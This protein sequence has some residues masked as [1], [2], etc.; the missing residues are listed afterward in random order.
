MMLAKN[1]NLFTF[2]SIFVWV[3]IFFSGLFF[4]VG[5]DPVYAQEQAPSA[6]T[7][8]G[9]ESALINGEPTSNIFVEG[10]KWVLYMLI[11]FFSG[12]VN[13]AATV[14]AWATE[15]GYISGPTGL[16]NL[17][18][19]YSLW[20]FIRDFFNLAFIFL[21]L[22]S[23][24]GTIFQLHQ[25]NLKKNFFAIIAAAILINFSFPLTR[26]V[27]DFGNVPMYFFRDAIA[28]TGEG[29]SVVDVPLS[30][31]KQSA[32]S[33]IMFPAER[34]AASVFSLITGVVFSFMFMITLFALSVL[35]ILR[36]IKLVILLIFS[37][38][39]VAASI[40]P[41]L[42]KYGKEWWSALLSTVF[43]GP[44]AM[45]MLV[46]ALR[47]MIELN[48]SAFSQGS[49]LSTEA[50]ANSASA[51]RQNS[52]VAQ[53]VFFIPIILMWMAMSV[54]NKFGIEGAGMVMKQADKVLNWGKGAAKKSA[55]YGSGLGV[56]KWG[57]KTGARKIDSKLASTKYGKY[58]SPSAVKKAFKD[59][60]AAKKHEDEQPIEQAA[61]DIHDSLNKRISQAKNIGATVLPWNLPLTEKNRQRLKDLAHHEF[62][63]DHSE[64]GIAAFT[65]QAS[66]AAKHLEATSDNYESL[67]AHIDTAR[68]KKD[69]QEMAGILKLLVRNNDINEIVPD[70]GVSIA[71]QL[72][73]RNISDFK[74]ED[75]IRKNLKDGE[76]I[77]EDI[78]DQNG[79]VVGR[80]RTVNVMNQVMR[81]TSEVN[82][83]GK[84]TMISDTNSGKATI[85]LSLR[86]TGMDDATITGFM[87]HLGNQ[88]LA[89]GNGA[90][91][92]MVKRDGHGGFI[93]TSEAEQARNNAGKLALQDPQKIANGM[94]ADTIFQRGGESGYFSLN[95]ETAKAVMDATFGVS[96]GNQA[97]RMKNTKD[98]FKALWEQQDQGLAEYY[99]KAKPEQQ[100]AIAKI[101][102]QAGVWGVDPKD[103]GE[104]E[105]LN[106]KTFND[107]RV[108][109]QSND[110][111]IPKP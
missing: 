23:A 7:S 69:S 25:F 72:K 91:G 78:L 58:L 57:A 65:K 27:I 45:L 99:D 85:A 74:D 44:A 10:I 20:K 82:D 22:F 34:K 8:A 63:T 93:L 56:A 17:E 28:G 83:A 108:R 30:F 9:I 53:G 46:I 60:A 68:V 13:V 87:E 39:G 86:E 48:G 84:E 70:K 80:Q 37:P 76:Q 107:A 64:H 75:D 32:L 26:I 29:N 1:K 98:G 3:F 100:Y 2:I 38:L 71:S 35:F 40:V 51:A 105:R 24:F 59:R 111:T 47:F 103:M 106:I 88:S 42:E 16:L 67:K 77:I 110:W 41:G 79:K 18:V 31:F 33:D 50:G 14:F 54:G 89:A 36:L 49:G 55:Y 5:V 6:A 21:L 109:S 52:I 95:G 97:S 15:P 101:M 73:V 19:V 43:F 61:A 11:V 104:F 92:N 90:F 12:L 62:N 4:F 102:Y 81:L 94:H 66:S 96:L